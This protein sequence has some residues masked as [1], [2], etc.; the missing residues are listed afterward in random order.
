[1]EVI[2]ME[3][4][5]ELITNGNYEQAVSLINTRLK[6]HD[7]DFIDQ[8]IVSMNIISEQA[9]IIIENTFP[10]LLS[11]F[12]LDDDILRYSLLL[13]LAAFLEKNPSM[14]FPY[15]KENLTSPSPRIRESMLCVL[16]YLVKVNHEIISYLPL[17]ANQLCAQEEYVAKKAKEVLI[18]LG[19]IEPEIVKMEISKLI[20]EKNSCD[21][22]EK[23]KDI[24]KSILD[25]TASR[26]E[27]FKELELEA[28]KKVL[29]KEQK[30][31]EKI[32]EVQKEEAKINGEGIDVHLQEKQKEL[33]KREKELALM[34]LKLKEEELELKELETKL[35][36]EEIRKER[37]T[38]SEELKIKKEKE[39]LELVKKELELK[40]LIEEKQKIIE[41]EEKRIALK[42]KELEEEQD[43]EDDYEEIK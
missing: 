37:D 43:S 36:E 29:E 12:D 4:I 41:Q 16:T 9:P 15:I 14:I 17:I 28:K 26:P 38:L 35:K 7:D 10:Q 11:L 31:L 3:K 24:L 18:E 34:K 19:K 6:K 23:S 2:R 39:A 30:I 21:F 8:F 27:H 25:V 33:E 22:A 40:A 20:Q 1:V 32:S 42:E 5:M 13:K